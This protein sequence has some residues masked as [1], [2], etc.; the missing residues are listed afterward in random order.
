[1]IDEIE[2]QGEKKYRCRCTSS[3][4]WGNLYVRLQKMAVLSGSRNKNITNLGQ[5]KAILFCR[6]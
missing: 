3:Y 4:L 5:V 6:R 2:L 1:V